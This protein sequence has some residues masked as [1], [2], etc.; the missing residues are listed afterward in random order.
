M[1]L[2]ELYR[3]ET[4]NFRNPKC[5]N[6]ILWTKISKEINKHGY[7]VTEEM[8][9]RKF[10]N[11][12][13]TFK[14]IKDTKRKTGRG[15]QTWEFFDVMDEIFLSDATINP[16]H[17]ISS[18]TEQSRPLS[19]NNLP[20]TSIM[21]PSLPTLTT[22]PVTSVSSLSPLTPSALSPDCQQSATTSQSLSRTTA[23]NIP[24]LNSSVDGTLRKKNR[25]LAEFRKHFIACEEK[26]LKELQEIKQVY[27]E[28]LQTQKERN[29]ILK[30]VV[31]LL[32]TQKNVTN[33]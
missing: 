19:V 32:Q 15:R 5:K 33:S 20:S 10:R 26:K 30:E 3:S 31:G 17:L 14:T 25:D 13:G 21:S 23:S 22:L 24:N 9:D 7:S 11:L 4:E 18:T 28:Q 12:K 1:L 29:N 27:K 6:S 16:P 8:C 2:L